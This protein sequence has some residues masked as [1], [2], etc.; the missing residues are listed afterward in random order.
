[1]SPKKDERPIDSSDEE[2]EQIDKHVRLAAKHSNKAYELTIRRNEREAKRRKK[3]QAEAAV[4]A[5]TANKEKCNDKE[6]G[7][8]DDKNNPMGGGFGGVT[9]ADAS[10]AA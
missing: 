8:D 6:D 7:G 3:A 4:S 5:A 2:K 10:V 1:M 9:S